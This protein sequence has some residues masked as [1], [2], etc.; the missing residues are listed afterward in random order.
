M[1]HKTHDYSQVAVAATLHCLTGCAIGEILGMVIG[2]VASLSNLTTILISTALA[3]VFGYSLSLMPLLKHGVEFKKAA[4]IVLAADTLSIL[5]MEIADNAVM[6]LVPGAM[7]ANLVNPLFWATM[8]VSLF[9][10]FLVAVPV[11]QYLL[12]R[13]KGHALMHESL[14]HG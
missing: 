2:N 8:P 7:N 9:V 6:A 10:G 1:N 4:M 11:N 12:N 3:F 13:G 5:S 14:H